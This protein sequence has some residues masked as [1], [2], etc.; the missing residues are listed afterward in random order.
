MYIHYSEVNVQSEV[1]TA[2]YSVGLNFGKKDFFPC[3]YVLS[4]YPYGKK[5]KKINLQQYSF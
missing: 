1:K 2:Y 5:K 3:I 4:F